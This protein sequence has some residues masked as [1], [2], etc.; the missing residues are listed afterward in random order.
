MK[1]NLKNYYYDIVPRTF[2][3]AQIIFTDG[4]FIEHGY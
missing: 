3:K 2:G 1:K 4:N